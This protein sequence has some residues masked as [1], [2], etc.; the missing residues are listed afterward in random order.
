MS[1][2]ERLSRLTRD[3]AAAVLIAAA[4]SAAVGFAASAN[5]TTADDVTLRPSVFGDPEASAEHWQIQ[6]ARPL[7]DHRGHHRP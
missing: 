4:G 6:T 1:R 5:A 7:R 2:T 3:V